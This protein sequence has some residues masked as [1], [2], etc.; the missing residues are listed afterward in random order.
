MSKHEKGS[1]S[2]A[3]FL[4]SMLSSCCRPFSKDTKFESTKTAEP[5]GPEAKMV[6]AAKHF[7]HK[8]HLG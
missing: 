4:R 8:V 6:A 3:S 2:W 7:S 1:S 5:R